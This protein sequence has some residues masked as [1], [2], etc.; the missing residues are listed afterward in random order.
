MT[1]HYYKDFLFV[2]NPVSGGTD[3]K[4]VI[5][6]IDERSDVEKFS[7]Q[8]YTTTGK[9]DEDAIIQL[10]DR[11]RPDK[12]IAVGGDGTLMLLA[13]VFKD[14]RIKIGLIPTGSANGMATELGIPVIKGITEAIQ[15]EKLRAA[16]DIIKKEKIKH[17]DLVKINDQYSL[18]MSDVGFN[19]RIVE[20]FHKSGERG[21]LGYARQFIKEV[22]ERK[23]FS[24]SLTACEANKS[25]KA[26]MIAIAN[27]RRY[28]TGAVINP[29]GKLDDG[30]VEL[31]II[32]ELSLIS[33][34]YAVSSI[35]SEEPD[36]DPEH[37]EMVSC[38]SATIKLDKPE[39]LQVDGELAG[40]VK[41]V[42]VEVLPGNVQ[43][44]C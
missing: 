4:L 32:K 16:W 42:D 17:L 2:L 38:S 35:I 6:F 41:R 36:Y 12:L 19:A 5:E 22:K 39:I 25:G 33:L 26:V 30:E 44:I 8:I 1:D 18:H 13:G 40:K 23:K 21:F 3:K 11:H 7:Y 20:E 10:V 37:V 29:D 31:V 27:A 15:Q 14:R 43:M 28:G 9:K 34:L 24:Y